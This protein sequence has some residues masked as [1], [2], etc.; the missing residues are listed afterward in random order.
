M[1]EIQFQNRRAVRVEN[2]L[3]RV[4][5]TI[6]GAHLAEILH[7]PSGVNPLWIPPWPSIEPSTYNF[8]KHPE[9]GVGAEAHLLSGILGHNICLDTFGGP[10]LEEAAA[11]MPVH[12]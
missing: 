6:E 8:A 12:G 4:T 9:Y 7:K 3:V 5:S 2:E 10:S 11:G 1:A